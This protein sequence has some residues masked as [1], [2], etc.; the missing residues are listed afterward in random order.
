[1][2]FMT[3]I[4]R[5]AFLGHSA[6]SLGGL[7]LAHLLASP[8]A[9]AEIA[10][11][12]KARAVICLFQHGGPSQMD[13][14]D[15]KPLLT[16]LDGKPYP[17]GDLEVHF[18]KQKGNCLG[19]PY[20]FQKFGQ[21]GMELCELLPHTGS[22][23]DDICLVRSMKTE[24]VDHEAALRLFHSGRLFAGMPVWPSWAMYALGNE[25]E[26]LPAYVVLSDPGGLPVDGEHNWSSGWLPAQYQGTTFR[27]GSSPVFNLQSPP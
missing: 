18:D 11:K 1:M 17:G 19:S 13:L 23:A 9:A 22:I 6:G 3:D 2:K 4:T 7:A 16:K 26:N 21:C 20:K 8:S 12:P 10:S 24:S 15:P 25:N 14:F 27:S 5:R